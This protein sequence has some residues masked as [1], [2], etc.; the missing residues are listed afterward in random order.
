M[1]HQ[2]ATES[3]AA[4]TPKPA[5]SAAPTPAN[6]MGAVEWM[7]P[8]VLAY[9]LAVLLVL[10][11]FLILACAQAYRL[12]AL[13][14][15]IGAPRHCGESWKRRETRV[16]MERERTPAVSDLAQ[17]LDERRTRRGSGEFS[18]QL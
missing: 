2:N 11:I 16:P 7:A 12:I 9:A 6:A 17:F 14:D 15:Q 5:A 3:P 4:A 1:A 10:A 13:A 18:L 8:D